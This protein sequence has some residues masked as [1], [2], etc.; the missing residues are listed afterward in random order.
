MKLPPKSKKCKKASLN[1]FQKGHLFTGS[2]L[3]QKGRVALFDPRGDT[4]NGVLQFLPLCTNPQT[5]A[6]APSMRTDSGAADTFERG[7]TLANME[8]THNED[9]IHLQK[10]GY[11]L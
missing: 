2:K 5:S 6:K 1:R 11:I 7:G 8:S 3:K 4:C 9:L 10:S